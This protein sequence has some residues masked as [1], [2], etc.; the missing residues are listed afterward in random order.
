MFILSF[1]RLHLVRKQSNVCTNSEV[2]SNDNDIV[3]IPVIENI[4]VEKH[5]PISSPS[6][7]VRNHDLL[8]QN[9]NLKRLVEREQKKYCNQ[10][11]TILELRSENA[12]FKK[13]LSLRNSFKTRYRNKKLDVRKK[14]LI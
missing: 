13:K 14:Q 5:N 8:V 6:I 7:N 9:N 1:Y 4:I 11:R 12:K 3:E 2:S 10:R